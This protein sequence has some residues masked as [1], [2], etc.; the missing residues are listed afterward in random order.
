MTRIRKL[1][2]RRAGRRDRSRPLA[3]GIERLERRELLASSIAFNSAARHVAVQGTDLH[4]SLGI[5]IL[6][7][8]TVFTLKEYA[9]P[10]LLLGAGTPLKTTERSFPTAQIDV[11]YF[12]GFGGG[13]YFI[14]STAL[15]SIVDGGIGNDWLSGGSGN[16]LLAGN[17]GND[18]LSGNDG[19]DWLTGV[20]GD[21]TVIGGAGGDLLD[22]GLGRDKLYGNAG[23]DT[24]YGG[25]GDD[26]MWGGS[27]VD[28]LW[29]GNGNDQLNGEANNDYLNGGLGLD[30]L[31]GGSGHDLLFGG[32]ADG[33]DTL[34]GGTGSDVF[35]TVWDSVTDSS[36]AQQDVVRLASEPD[37]LTVRV[38]IVK[39][40]NDDGSQASALTEAEIKEWIAEANDAYLTARVEFVFDAAKDLTSIK[41]TL[42]NTIDG[43]T[44]TVN[45]IKVLKKNYANQ[46]AAANREALKYPGKLVVFSRGASGL[47]IN[48][49][50]T[51]A[52]F[53]AMSQDETRFGVL[54]HEMGH[55]L[56]LEHT[57]SDLDNPM[58]YE[59]M[60]NQTLRASQITTAR[61]QISGR[62]ADQFGLTKH[63]SYYANQF[64]MGEV[65]LLGTKGWYF[66]TPNGKVYHS[67]A[68]RSSTG[69][70][71]M[72]LDR[73]VSADT[74]LTAKA[75]IRSQKAWGLDAH[76]QFVKDQ[77]P[78][79][80]SQG[81][82]W[83]RGRSD[84][85]VGGVVG[86]RWYYLTSTGRLYA[87]NGKLIDVLGPEFYADPKKLTNANTET[88]TFG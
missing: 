6:G 12:Q 66:M 70:F 68:S 16:D 79:A 59:W 49:S 29:G 41:S 81:R 33:I 57:L 32:S 38:H 54:G 78:A 43:G 53:V 35:F 52:N 65:W 48:F 82:K 26:A 46:I 27:E 86:N 47:R 77:N 61:Q 69:T 72:Q 14:N 17:I 22:A 19:G 56:G 45:G 10:I 15:A 3:H 9:Q 74:M 30:V 7:P 24:L 4:D 62:F 2:G 76:F 37:L 8:N 84:A 67:G 36:P 39:V 55:Y 21:D 20:A 88:W 5:K 80:D 63:V 85:L 60:V 13:D 87:S 73:S 18:I 25:D 44:A 42:I 31:N 75:L 51:G 83:L 58:S 34:T 1:T 71:V 40:A 11:V 50:G 28:R 23:R 64:G